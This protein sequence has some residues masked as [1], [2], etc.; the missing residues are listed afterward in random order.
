MRELALVGLADSRKL[1]FELDC[2]VWTINNAEGYSIPRIDRLFDLHA[3]EELVANERF[4]LLRDRPRDYSV[5]LLEDAPEIP[6]SFAYPRERIEEAVF[7]KLYRGEE[8]THYFSSSFAWMLALAVEDNPDLEVLHVCGFE[9]GSETE[10]RY[11][12]EGAY[13]LIC[14]ALGKGI[15]VRGPEGWTLFSPTAYGFGEYQMIS[16]QTL[17]SYLTDVAAQNSDA[18]GKLNARHALYTEKEIE[19]KRA[20]ETNGGDLSVLEKEI[21]ELNTL[22]N[23]AFK[24]VYKSAGALYVLDHLIRECD[25]RAGAFE[26]EEFDPIFRTTEEGDVVKAGE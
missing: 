3:K 13:A 20:I 6:N 25:R 2:P 17:E 11:Q 23:D 16:R 14:W 18:L 24:N 15:E 22:R 12:R 21:A 26:L 10:Y 9:F 1:V 4:E 7:G 8:K 5:Y 19:L